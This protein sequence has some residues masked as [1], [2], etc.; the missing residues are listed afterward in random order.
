MLET[1]AMAILGFRSSLVLSALVLA[2]TPESS[3][4]SLGAAGASA[5]SAGTGGSATSL[6]L[7]FETFPAA[8]AEAL[9]AALAR[10]DCPTLQDLPGPCVEFLTK[11]LRD[12]LAGSASHGRTFDPE[13]ASA[14]LEAAR[15]T[16]CDSGREIGA[17]CQLLYGTASAGEPCESTFDC[18]RGHSCDYQ[19]SRCVE[20]RSGIALGGACSEHERCAD[21]TYCEQASG[22]CQ[23]TLPLGA[24]CSG[25][26]ECGPFHFCDE[27]RRCRSYSPHGDACDRN[28]PCMGACEDGVCEAKLCDWD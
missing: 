28:T 7:T 2:C 26:D 3:G 12:G 5:G 24:Q 20:R 9:C 19:A 27:S 10:C 14:G 17:P 6:E 21:G 1:S 8:F 23:K 11:E 16:P 4:S 25:W 18:A 13:C 15:T 22:T